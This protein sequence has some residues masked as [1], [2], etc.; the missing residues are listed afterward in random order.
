VIRGQT[1]TA[2]RA[3]EG[4]KVTAYVFGA[5]GIRRVEGVVDAAGLLDVQGGPFF[6]S[7]HVGY[8]APTE[9]EAR[10][11]YI[12]A[13]ER[14]QAKHRRA[15]ANLDRRIRR[16]RKAGAPVTRVRW[17][18]SSRVND[19]AQVGR[20]TVEVWCDAV[21]WA[22]RLAASGEKPWRWRVRDGWAFL[23]RGGEATEREA[24]R[25]ARQEARRLG[26]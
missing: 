23:A 6:T 13:L 19:V 12:A 16:L 24:K 11:L 2:G 3:P 1:L 25:R 17:E 4:S 26:G 9:A 10:R 7:Y 22:E 20:L 21:E 8:W 18:R 5:T 14:E 15:I